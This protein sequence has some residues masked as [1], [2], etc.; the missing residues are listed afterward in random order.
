MHVYRQNG[1]KHTFLVEFSYCMIKFDS[2]EVTK[3]LFNKFIF[4]KD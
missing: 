3:K 2:V 4:K 1:I